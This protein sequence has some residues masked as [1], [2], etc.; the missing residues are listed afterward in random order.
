MFTLGH[1][2]LS[3]TVCWEMNK[4]RM[5]TRMRAKRVKTSGEIA[6]VFIAATMKTRLVCNLAVV[7]QVGAVSLYGSFDCRVLFFPELSTSRKEQGLA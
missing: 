7:L 4:A 6:A 5:P 3:I 1:G 2:K